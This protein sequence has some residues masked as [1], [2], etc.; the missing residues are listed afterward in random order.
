MIGPAASKSE[1]QA[2]KREVTCL[3]EK[4]QRKTAFSSLLKETGWM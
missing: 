3:V 1:V 4:F 2:R